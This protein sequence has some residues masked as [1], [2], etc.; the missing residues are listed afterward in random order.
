MLD[1]LAD[2]GIPIDRCCRVLGVARQ[3]YYRVK[4]K[5][6]TQAELRR[7]WLTGLIREVHV[8]SRGTYGYR[9]VHA[10]LTMAMGVTVSDKTV[11]KLMHEAGIYG[12][13][14]PIRTKR[15]R[16]IVTADDLV[17]RKF[18]RPRP[19]ELWVTDITQHR[20]REGWV[21]CAAVLDA[22]S[23]R[24][25]GWS[26]DSKQD[27]TLVINALDMAIRN[28]RPEPGGIVHADHGTQG[29]FNRSSQHLDQGG[30]QRWRR[31]TGVGRSATCLR[32]RGGSGGRIGRCAGRC[33]LLGG[34][35]RRGRCSGSSGV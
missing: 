16:G 4:R 32:G 12:L 26:I 7:Q 17:N 34:L 27:T 6:L 15:L 13:P 2:A 31:R 35:T 33:V 18:A 22:Y 28:R 11:F 19:N 9:R 5:P 30:V 8:T 21:Y 14:G 23:R 25:I 20:T 3:H 29:G 1:R 24:I 10:E